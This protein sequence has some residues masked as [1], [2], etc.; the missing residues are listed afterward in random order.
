MGLLSGH[1]A[2]RVGGAVGAAC[3]ALSTALPAAAVI[4][5]RETYDGTD[6][7]SYD[8]CGPVVDATA[9]FSGRFSMRAGTG[10]DA[11]AFFAHDT[12]RF[13]EEHVR[14]SDGKAASLD[15]IL[16]WRETT[17]TRVEGSLF[18]FSSTFAGQV[19][20]RDADGRLVFRDRGTIR[21]TILFDTLGDDVPGGE[22]IEE[23]AFDLRGQYP[24]FTSD[25]F[26]E[27]WGS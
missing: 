6:A 25:V 16:N 14:R 3:L 7:W 19:A 1:A 15:G 5:M 4:D 13:H 23:L 2:R 8:D 11:S 17:A 21:A 26:C 12:F 20:M 22:L 10:K 9:T 24:G 27:Y 18:A